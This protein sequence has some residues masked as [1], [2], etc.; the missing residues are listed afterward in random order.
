MIIE[1]KAQSKNTICIISQH[2]LQSTW[3]MVEL[4][5]AIE[6]STEN[7]TRKLGLV[8]MEDVTNT[9]TS[10]CK[11][12]KHA[13]SLCNYIHINDGQFKTKMKQFLV[14]SRLRQQLRFFTHLRSSLKERMNRLRKP[15]MELHPDNRNEC[16]GGD[17][18]YP[19][20]FWVGLDPQQPICLSISS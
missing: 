17:M 10:E 15:A 5:T 9:T 8:L 16:Q 19:S 3:C 11:L 2:V 14:Q 18:I 4:E 1:A 12:L 6:Y 7:T 20:P 13:M